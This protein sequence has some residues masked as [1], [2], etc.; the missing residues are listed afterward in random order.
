ML[1]R[2]GNLIKF[3]DIFGKKVIVKS[4]EI[5][6]IIFDKRENVHVFTKSGR[7]FMFTKDRYGCS[8]EVITIMFC[9]DTVERYKRLNNLD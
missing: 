3:T 4:E 8:G 9:N 7:Q 5:E 1:S 2:M 6:S